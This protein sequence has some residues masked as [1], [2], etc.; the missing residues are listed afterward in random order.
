[1]SGGREQAACGPALLFCPHSHSHAPLE[2]D[3]ILP[4]WK[5]CRQV[6]TGAADFRQLFRRKGESDNPHGT[7]PSRQR[8]NAVWTT[9]VWIM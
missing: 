4:C 5:L 1:M 9:R 2:P 6:R 3:W 7:G 8:A